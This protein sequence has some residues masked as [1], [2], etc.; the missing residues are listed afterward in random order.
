MTEAPGGAAL[1][2]IEGSPLAVAMRHQLWLYPTVEIIH[3]TGFVILVGSV[4][5]LDLRLLGLSRELSVR[6]MA[7]HVLPWSWGA[8]LLI[9]PT[10]LLMF[11]THAG[12][13]L[14]NRAFQLKLLLILCA[15]VNAAI[16]HANAYRT[17]SSWDTG[18]APP[19][20]ARLHALASLALWIGVIACGRLL[21]YL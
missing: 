8:L 16:F 20:A 1:A 5:M 4:A 17:V 19:R 3:I 7:R 12:D 14:L 11:I 2:A 10:G 15:G 9:V 6:R 13:F 21:A 18:S